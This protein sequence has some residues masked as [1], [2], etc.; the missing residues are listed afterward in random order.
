MMMVLVLLQY[1]TLS[2]PTYPP[3]RISH[4]SIPLTLSNLVHLEAAIHL[5]IEPSSSPLA[6][7]HTNEVFR[8]CFTGEQWPML[9]QKRRG[10]N[11]EFNTKPFSIHYSVSSGIP[12]PQSSSHRAHPVQNGTW[13]WLTT[14]YTSHCPLHLAAERDTDVTSNWRKRSPT[15]V[16]SLWPNDDNNNA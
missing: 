15:I 14:T 2:A 9:N 12:E 3:P 8:K 1:Y 11:N 6:Y 7:I 4:R 10:R 16:H 5:F 13:V